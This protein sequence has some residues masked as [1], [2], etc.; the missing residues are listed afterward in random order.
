MDPSVSLFGPVDDYVAPVL[1]YVLLALAVLNMVGRG[2]EYNRIVDQA[3]EGDDDEL[4]SRHPLRVATNF[5]LVVGAFYLLTVERHAGMVVSLLV[6]GVFVCDLFEFESRKV[7]A[8]QGWEIERPW[9]SL[10]GSVL[11]LM[12]V[13]YQIFDSLAP[14]WEVVI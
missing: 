12:Y 5:L 1:I 11:V 7:E 2:L 14:F 8:R 9:S 3:E 13:V 6:V 10:V 4:L